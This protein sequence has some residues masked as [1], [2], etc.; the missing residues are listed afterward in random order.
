MTI[1]WTF[2]WWQELDEELEDSHSRK[3]VDDS[4]GSWLQVVPST[5]MIGWVLVELWQLWVTTVIKI[6]I[7]ENNS[8][9]SDTFIVA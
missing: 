4:R 1:Y 6:A 9:Y 5:L 3:F 7:N 2:F 8:N